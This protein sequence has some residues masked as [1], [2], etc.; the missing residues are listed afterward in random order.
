MKVAVE[1]INITDDVEI[2]VAHNYIAIY[3]R[4]P[5]GRMA[6]H[7]RYAINYEIS[8]VKT[9]GDGAPTPPA[10]STSR[11]TADGERGTAYQVEQETK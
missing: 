9:W 1:T 8:L 2:R 5:D 11:Q 10:Q 6:L 7:T 3:K 4:L